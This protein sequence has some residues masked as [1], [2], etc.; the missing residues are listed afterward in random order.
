MGSL[1]DVVIHPANGHAI[2]VAEI[3]AVNRKL[4]EIRL[5]IYEAI[6]RH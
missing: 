5:Q 6:P 3:D 2:D 1:N 4:S